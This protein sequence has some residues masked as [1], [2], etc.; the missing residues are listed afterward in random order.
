MDNWTDL[1][2]AIG[3]GYFAGRLALIVLEVTTLFLYRL[4]REREA[5]REAEEFER[6]L[7]ELR[8]RQAEARPRAAVIRVPMTR[9]E[10]LDA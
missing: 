8:E 7:R 9:R 3:V 5:E 1:A 2:L 10:D 6:F 4:Y